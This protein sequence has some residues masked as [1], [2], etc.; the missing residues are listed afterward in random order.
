ME[1]VA[2]DTRPDHNSLGKAAGIT[3]ILAL[4]LSF[5]PFI[6]FVSWLLAPLAILFSLFALR[7]TPRSMAIVGL[8]TG[9]LA[10]VVCF[11]WI[12]ATKSVGEAMSA[13]T[14]NPSGEARDNSNAEVMDASIKTLWNDIEAN[15]VAAGQRYGGKRLAFTDE[16]IADFGGDAT[17][18]SIQ[19]IGK[20]D[21]YLNYF[22]TASFSEKDGPAIAQMAKGDGVSFICNEISESFGEGYNLRECTLG[23]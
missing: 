10:L 8:I 12:G 19:I 3:G 20:S 22:V 15:K 1:T 2:T 4:I 11:T 17:N 16:K 9:A 13:D 7:R 5:V 18:P 14:F 6:G 21:G 23:H